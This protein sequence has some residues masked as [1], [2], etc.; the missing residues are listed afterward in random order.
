M[1]KKKFR[2]LLDEFRV[3]SDD[4]QVLE[5]FNDSLLHSLDYFHDKY[6][7]NR[8]FDCF[9]LWQK[10]I[11]DNSGEVLNVWRFIAQISD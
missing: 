7:N 1:S 9:I 6:I 8:S 2:S 3:T 11:I 5:L 4:G 10:I